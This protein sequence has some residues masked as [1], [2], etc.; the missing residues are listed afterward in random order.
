M[1]TTL[2]RVA[3]VGQLV[4]VIASLAIPAV[5]GWREEAAR[6][7]PITRRVFWVWA[8]YIWCAHIAFGLVSSLTPE[9]LTDRTPLASVVSGFIATWWGARLGLQFVLFDRAQAKSPW[10]GPR[11]FAAAEAA[12]VVLFASLAIV[13]AIVALGVGIRP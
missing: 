11:A 5:L 2:V 1:L 4:L 3:G 13:Y 12:L 9:L 8:A 7:S 10:L 6:L